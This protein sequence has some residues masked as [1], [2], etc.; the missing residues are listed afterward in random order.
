MERQERER[1]GDR[2]IGV[3]RGRYRQ[4]SRQTKTAIDKQ[5]KTQMYGQTHTKQRKVR[6]TKRHNDAQTHRDKY[7]KARQANTDIETDTRNTIKRP[8]MRL[9]DCL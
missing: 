2:Q 9:I 6:Q 4:T 3:R 5:A 8:S 7:K 1:Q